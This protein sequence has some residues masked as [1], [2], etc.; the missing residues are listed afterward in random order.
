[1]SERSGLS[2]PPVI[3]MLLILGMSLI[4]VW[5]AFVSSDRKPL[6]TADEAA[7]ALAE[8]SRRGV[9]PKNGLDLVGSDADL[10]KFPDP[11]AIEDSHS[12]MLLLLRDIARRA[13]E[14]NPFLGDAQAT[15]LR[16]ALSSL[17]PNT[18]VR[19]RFELLNKLGIQQL[20]LGETEEA[21][22]RFRECLSLVPSGWT[23]VMNRV[24]YQLAIAYLRQAENENCVLCCNGDS[25]ILPIRANGIHQNRA[26]SENAIKHLSALLART[27]EHVSARWLLNLAHMT[28]GGFPAQVPEKLRISPDLFKS[29]I[30]FPRFENVA[31]QLNLDEM[32][33]AGG[34][35]VDD[36]NGDGHLDIVTSQWSTSG[37]LR[38]YLSQ[39]DGTFEDSTTDAG[40]EGI[41]GGLNLIQA[42]YDND[43]DIDI[44]VL[45]GAWWA[46]A[47]CHPNSLLANDGQGHF[48]DVTFEAGLG[49]VHYP[50]QTASWADYDND[51]DL[52]LY[53]GNELFPC[54]LFQ[55][56]GR[57]RFIDVAKKAGVDDGGFAKGVVW[58]DY[59]GDR[60]PDI[61]VSNLDGAN[62]LFRNNRDGTFTNV[63]SELGVE[64]PSRSFATW[65]WD[66]NNDGVLD[67][68][69]GAYSANI[70]I[71]A[72]DY[73]G[74]PHDGETDRLYQGD[75]AGGFRDVSR[76][77][78]VDRVTVPMGANFGD[79]DNDG[80]LDFYLGTGDPNFDSLMPNRMYLN[81]RGAGF[82][83]IS[84]AGGF[85][86]LQKGHGVAFA[87]FNRD[88]NQDVFIELGGAYPGDGFANALFQNPGFGNHWF[89]VKLVGQR[90]NSQGL[91]ARIQAV[92]EEGGRS[93]SIY[94]W[95]NSGGSFGA[96][97]LRV[98]LGV[99]TAKSIKRLEVY[100][101]TSDSVQAFEN[102]PVDQLIQITEHRERFEKMPVES[103]VSTTAK[104]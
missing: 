99:G 20:Q 66:F 50:T 31:Q 23:D 12:R 36:F 25:C 64:K 98:H 5:Q 72:A 47:G 35:I 78:K 44:L 33:L 51:G 93:R 43:G 82:T 53:I 34:V 97:P 86:H 9:Q 14:E 63:A 76:E 27:P 80:Y 1:M 92:I 100:W 15:R 57:G 18:D 101:P 55:N 77:M 3:W 69:V 21:I 83:D 59:N 60:F 48:R 38:I 74:L 30:E 96:N 46:E 103:L 62:R 56:N 89:G 7:H 54:Q 81:Q 104:D 52:D 37:Q 95:V 41:L 71:F 6:L 102:V 85:A 17:S 13:P 26:G 87:D 39:G 29:A 4:V 67:L 16:Q 84:S 42:D 49:A 88:G 68:F 79:L 10:D 61:Y 28:L 2:K 32:S 90:S 75:G 58:G 40:L 22:G 65:F 91:G 24:E 73:L 19:Q 45:R 11:R 8:S 94:R 70:G